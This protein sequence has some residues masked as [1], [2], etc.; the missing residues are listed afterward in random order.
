MSEL[1]ESIM[2]VCFGLSWPISLA[3]NIKAH[4]AKNMSLRFTLLIILGY[5]AGIMGKILNGVFNYVLIVYLINLVIVS[6]NLVVYFV[7]KRY[8]RIAA[9]KP[10]ELIRK[11][12]QEKAI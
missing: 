2:M 5:V 6:A 4:S 10:P 12:E 11:F 7:N 8:D 1:L 3:K 9:Q